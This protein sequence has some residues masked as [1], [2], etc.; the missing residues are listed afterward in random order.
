[1]AGRGVGKNTKSIITPGL[2][3]TKTD[4]AKGVRGHVPVILI[5]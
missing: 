2:E 4:E 1:M 3:D 5:L